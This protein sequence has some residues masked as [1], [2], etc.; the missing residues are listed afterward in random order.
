M[1]LRIDGSVYPDQEPPEVLLSLIQKADYVHRIVAALDF[2]L[3]P[4]S[5]TLRLFRGWQ[6]VFDAYPLPASPGYH[7]LRAFFAW[8]EVPGAPF[9]APPAYVAQDAREGRSD[10]CEHLV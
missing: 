2:G 3:P 10:G 4:D 9:A 7:A 1:T 6:E 5:A 8:P